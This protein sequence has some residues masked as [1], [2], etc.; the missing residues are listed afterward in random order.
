MV[1]VEIV[2]QKGPLCFKLLSRRTGKFFSVD[3]LKLM[4]TVVVREFHN[5]M[6]TGKARATPPG[7]PRPTG[8][9]FRNSNQAFTLDIPDLYILPGRQQP[10]VLQQA[11]C[12]RACNDK[13]GSIG[14]RGLVLIRL[15]KM[16]QWYLLDITIA[17]QVFQ[18]VRHPAMVF[19]ISFR[20]RPQSGNVF[21]AGASL[22]KAV[23]HPVPGNGGG[24]D[25]EDNYRDKGPPKPV[26]RPALAPLFRRVFAEDKAKDHA[27]NKACQGGCNAGNQG[28]FEQ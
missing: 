4:M 3:S 17:H 14:T 7:D 8:Q 20:S 6:C 19:K 12:V 10:P 18:C 5:V 11:V 9:S 15:V 1:M 27:Q 13:T 24:K 26:L 23:Y 16:Q 22:Q 28:Y 25:K 21:F 2:V